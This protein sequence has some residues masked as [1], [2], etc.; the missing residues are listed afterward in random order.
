[1]RLLNVRVRDYASV[2]RGL[3][4]Y[5]SG[6]YLGALAIFSK[7]AQ[8]NNSSYIN[9]RS[10][11]C[12]YKLGEWD[13][14]LEYFEKAKTLPGYD[15]SWDVQYHSTKKN[16]DKTGNEY[17]VPNISQ[18]KIQYDENSNSLTAVETYA[19]VLIKNKSYWIAIHI[20]EDYFAHSAAERSL[21]L[22]SLL[23]ISYE[24]L[25]NYES[26]IIL[27][28]E[29]LEKNPNLRSKYLYSYGY[30][31]SKIGEAKFSSK[32]Y[33]EF[34]A[35]S[36]SLQIQQFG[37]AYEHEKQERWVE[38]SEAYVS[39]IAIEKNLD[40]RLKQY[41]KIAYVYGRMYDWAQSAQYYQLHIDQSLSADAYVYFKCGEAFEKAENFDKAAE[42]YN[43]A[44]LRSSDYKEYWYYRYAYVLASAGLNQEASL[45][46]TESRKNTLPYGIDPKTVIKN[47]TQSF[48]A[49]YVQYYETLPIKQNFIF[50]ESFLGNS[51]SC[52][53]FA[54][55]K[56]M[57][58]DEDFKDFRFIVSLTNVN[59]LPIELRDKR[60]IVIRRQSDAYQRYLATCKYLINN[61]TFPYYFIRRPEQIYLNTWHGTPLKT[62][63]KDIAS[64]L[65]DYANV[66]RNFLQCTHIISQNK[67]TND[68][69]LEKYDIKNMYSGLVAETGYPRVDLTLNL[70]EARKS[71]VL[72]ILGIDASKPLV[73][74]APTW[75]GTSQG[76]KFDAEKLLNDL[77]TLK[78]DEYYLIFKAH[79]FAEEAVLKANLDVIISPKDIDTNE[80]LGCAD[81]L[82][83]DYSSIVFD[84]LQRNKPIISYI[85]D[86]DEYNQ[87]R[88]LYVDESGFLGDICFTIGQ[89]KKA[90]ASGLNQEVNYIEH[91]NIY[92]NK[93]NGNASQKVIDFVFKGDLSCQYQYEKKPV[94]LLFEG[95]FI[96]NGISRSFN[97]LLK[98][99]TEKDLSDPSSFTVVINANDIKGRDACQTEFINNYLDTISYQPRIGAMPMSIEELW[100]RQQFE[101]HYQINSSNFKDCYLKMYAR[102]ARRLFG[103]TRFE[104]VV[105]F[106]GYALFWVALLSQVSS[107]K[108][109]IY[110]H[111]DIYLEW[112]TRFPYLEGV[113]KLYNEYDKVVSV[114]ELTMINNRKNLAS[115]FDIEESKFA[116]GTNT[117]LIDEIKSSAQK[118][119]SLDPLFADHKG[120][121]IITI[122]RLSHEK[123]HEKLIRA[124]KAAKLNEKQI[125]LYIIGSG[126]LEDHLSGLIS[127]LSLNKWVYL[128]GQKSNP[129]P[130]LKQA[131]L[132]VL[133][134]NHEGQPMVLLEALVLKKSIVATDITGNRGMLGDSYGRLVDNSINGLS[135]GMVEFFEGNT[136]DYDEF[137]AEK[138]NKEALGQFLSNI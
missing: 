20:I 6:D 129:Y 17:K 137:D 120:K 56:A 136:F 123:D 131:D 72:N 18:A 88:G 66:A 110:Q 62:L 119:D 57:L 85:Y 3:G 40:L 50:F 70:T 37:I 45:I 1:M 79:H 135:E 26:A 30:C 133:S 115:R 105:N 80:L 104:S 16:I 114:S 42:Y 68:I 91:K 117:I 8:K 67:Y 126:P 71:R 55:L 47:N 52:N 13:K 36:N 64:P 128:L 81:I 84:F 5:K 22:L 41:L 87:E 121:K 134:S 63:G 38:A 99:L 108:H 59:D 7:L 74:Y 116:F 19:D 43:E 100:I 76:K 21:K 138:Y 83:S 9:F 44:I 107:N 73:V 103:D 92:A 48:L 35:E 130:Y 118:E 90:I 15:V 86:F 33:E 65:F 106:E 127:E 29:I 101:N 58:Q 28:E 89:V 31:L 25:S 96:P 61:V 109:I 132:F 102:E 12:H 2:Y 69:L 54:L 122:G 53:P 111:N 46:F 23:S 34:I 78:S 11:M 51:F 93:D 27:L 32:I 94:H 39:R 24:R 75:R 10:G 97:N 49:A 124:Y 112:Q 98:N 77:T 82:I 113:V 4:K 95:P 14:A 60:V 125:K